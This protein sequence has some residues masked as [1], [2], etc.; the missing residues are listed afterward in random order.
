MNRYINLSRQYALTRSPEVK[1]QMNA[2]IRNYQNKHG[3]PS[4]I[5]ARNALQANIMAARFPNG[6]PGRMQNAN[7]GGGCWF[8]GILNG[9]L[10]SYR[11]RKLLRIRLQQYKNTNL[12]NFQRAQKAV[13]PVCPMPGKVNRGVFWAYIDERLKTG[14]RAL[15]RMMHM[16]R[17]ILN[18]K[19]RQPGNNFGG[20]SFLEVDNVIRD[21]W[22]EFGTPNS[23]V[24]TLRY[25]PQRGHDVPS[26]LRL[27]PGY[28][29]YNTNL[30]T[31]GTGVYRVSHAMMDI[32][33]MGG[34]GGHLIIG[35][36]KEDGTQMLY[37]SNNVNSIKCNWRTDVECVRQ[38][39]IEA[40][41]K[42]AKGARITYNVVFIRS[43]AAN[44]GAPNNNV[45]IAWPPVNRLPVSPPKASVK[46]NNTTTRS[47]RVSKKPRT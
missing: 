19:L 45:P 13:G 46:R 25:S 35:Y 17:L 37:D 24:L 36:V 14:S 22:P 31:K 33:R 4:L 29:E 9:F 5:V 7:S 26:V 28:P 18:L 41:G 1:E 30:K 42:A 16:N 10:L 23:P 32:G 15:N 8:M 12:A 20:G 47:G 2:I 11:A 44:T 43:D 34:G 6:F 39:I 21:L 3:Y 40:Y 27:K 38:Y